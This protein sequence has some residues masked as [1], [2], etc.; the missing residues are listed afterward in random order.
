MR[1]L[2]MLIMGVTLLFL[3]VSCGDKEKSVCDTGETVAAADD[4]VD[5]PDDTTATK[6]DAVGVSSD[7]TP[8]K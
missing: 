3:A 8:T 7:V 1:N 6:A 2:F 4:V 5:S